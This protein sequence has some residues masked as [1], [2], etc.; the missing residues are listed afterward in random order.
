LNG[1]DLLPDIIAGVKFTDG[2]KSPE[3]AA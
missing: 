1:Y 2:V 3:V